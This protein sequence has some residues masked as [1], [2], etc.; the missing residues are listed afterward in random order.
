M[1]LFCP[2]EKR[3]NQYKF[4]TVYEDKNKKIENIS[5]NIFIDHENSY[6]VCMHVT[7]N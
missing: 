3:T 5:L 2:L 1:L 7:Q 6:T 4:Y